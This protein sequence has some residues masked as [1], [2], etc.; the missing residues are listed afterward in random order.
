MVCLERIFR[1]SLLRKKCHFLILVNTLLCQDN[2]NMQNTKRLPKTSW[3]PLCANNKFNQILYTWKWICMAITTTF[4]V[5]CV[6]FPI[7]LFPQKDMPT[8]WLITMKID[9]V[10]YQRIQTSNSKITGVNIILNKCIRVATCDIFINLLNTT[11]RMI[12]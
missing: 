6:V 8:I 12:C 7:S 11:Y 3:F 1:P 2:N 5:N 10:P 9:F 4:S